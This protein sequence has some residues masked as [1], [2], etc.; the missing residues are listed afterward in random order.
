VIFFFDRSIGTGIPKALREYLK[1]PGID[2]EYHQHWFDLAEQDDV[3]LPQIGAWN[4]LV[5]GQDYSYHERPTE[6]HAIKTYKVGAF[7]LWG[8]E[9]PKWETLRVFAKAY[10]KIIRAAEISI[11]PFAYSVDRRGR[12]QEIYL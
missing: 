12:L 10:D 6:L 9:E 3:W 11:K 5:I 1:P 4:W 2:V 8:A 7:Y